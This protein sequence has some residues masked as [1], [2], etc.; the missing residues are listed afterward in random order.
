MHRSGTSM[1][2]G[3][4]Q[5]LGVLLPGEQIAADQNNPEGYFE[6]REVVDL[7]ERLLIDLER[8]WPSAQG[9]LPLPE[10]WFDHPATVEC[11]LRLRSLLKKESLRQK[12]VWAIKDP[13]SS[14]L[15]PI[16]QKLTTEL[17]IPLKLVLAVRDPAEVV[18]SLIRRDGPVTGMN[19][20]RAQRLWWQHNLDVLN[21]CDDPQRLTLVEFSGWFEQPDRQIRQL[22]LDLPELQPKQAQLDDALAFI[23]PEHRHGLD[24]DVVLELAPAVLRL[25]RRLQ[26]RPLPRRWPSAIADGSLPLDQEPWPLQEELVADPG[27]WP[28]LLKKWRHYPAPRA[29]GSLAL[30]PGEV[31]LSSC[32]SSWLDWSSHL[33]LQRLPL[34]GLAERQLS[35][36]TSG[37]HQ[38]RLQSLRDTG[39]PELRITLNQELP[40]VD[41][42]VH[43]LNHLRVQQWIWDPD[44]A[45]V[46]LLRALGFP[47]WW[48]DPLT[49]VNGWLQQDSAASP[50]CW[51][52]HLGLVPPPKD[53]LIV[54]GAAGSTWDQALAAEEERGR[55]VEGLQ[56]A[57][58][59]GWQDLRCLEPGCALAA[60]GWLAKACRESARLFF[61]QSRD[62]LIDAD[63]SAL[64]RPAA[65][66][67]IVEQPLLP[68]GIRA[69]HRGE[70]LMALAED[71][72]PPLCDELFVWSIDTPPRVAVVVSSFN[73]EKRITTALKSVRD[74]SLSGLELIVV[75]DASQ[76]DSAGVIKSWMETQ[77]L[78]GDH[79]FVRL[80][81]L[82]HHQN[83]GLAVARNTAFEA[84]TSAWCFVLDADNRLL[85]E[86]V[87]ACLAVAE[88]GSE[89]PHLAVVHP[90]VGMEI[91]GDRSDEQRS[92][93]GGPSWQESGFVEG[94]I[95]DAMALVRRS[96]WRAVGGYTHL[97]G[98]WEDYDFWC[99]LITAGWHGLQCPRL[100]AL[101]R[102]HRQAMT[103]V[104]TGRSQRGL[105]RRLA[106][107][108][109]WL[110]LPLA[111]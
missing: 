13:R 106:L 28:A 60:A 89:C 96:A 103:F 15:L 20:G 54:L 38:L 99:K 75:D 7:Q 63:L 36:A 4:I 30:P 56:I 86:A 34:N 105:S 59:P 104:E 49:P 92:L 62:H 77:V 22:L 66:P 85:P 94:N 43:W 111:P 2:S 55:Q 88:S 68:E 90:L 87:Q 42:A 102:S 101:Y 73:Y 35:S 46:L 41:R 69:M 80:L 70:T 52:E 95:I 107:R 50:R 61:V 8:W 100:L 72:S 84:A 108:H 76:D 27:S 65:T 26:R 91:E 25:H 9:T 10:D 14:R 33:W 5:R 109:P 3:V 31:V 45:R 44:P 110:K 47:A 82:R 78:E 37:P 29:P 83:A 57:Y 51:G 79:P 1:L 53:H 24:Q 19:E 97:A 81:L 6:W 71:R 93:L 48:L 11:R 74:Q 21:V 58:L 16:W 32:G 67:L 18:R 98:G 12:G 23:K 40:S 39:E 64:E 17:D